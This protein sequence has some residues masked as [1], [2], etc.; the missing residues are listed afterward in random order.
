MHYFTLQRRNFLHLL[1]CCFYLYGTN[2][3]SNFALT[4]YIGDFNRS[5]A[6]GA[7]VA[8]DATTV[9]TNPAG[10][11]RLTGQQFS[12]SAQYFTT[13]AKFTDNGSKDALGSPL[14]G[15]NTG[16][17]GGNTFVPGIFYSNQLSP[18]LSFGLAIN[19]SFGLSTDYA[20]DWVG[21][22]TAITTSIMAM[23]INP[24]FTIKLNDAWSAG[25][26]ISAQQAQAKLSSAI[27]FGAVCLA[28][29]AP[30]TCASLGMPAPQS[31]DGYVEMNGSDWGSGY[32]F[33]LLWS[34]AN[35]QSSQATRVGM[36][37]R[38]K[39]SYQLTGDANF[40]IPAAATAFNPTFT[41]TTVT[42]PL[43]LPEI[44][45][46]SIYHDVTHSV[47]MMADIT[48][49][50]WSRFKNL[51]IDFANPAQPDQLIAKNWHD[52]NRY[53]IGINYQH[54]R[55]WV[56]Q[57]GVAYE[58]SPIPDSSYDPSIPVGNTLWLSL[59]AQYRFSEHRVL[60]AGWA[61]VQLQQREVNLTGNYGETLRGN[62]DTQLDVVN[63]RLNW[64]F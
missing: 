53:A 19:G 44:F 42:I 17:G 34:S 18:T 20:R 58:K 24:S 47:A 22:Y 35:N 6:G 13:A 33:G 7:A 10:L 51:S 15:G 49:T 26:G 8:E 40:S 30:S 50:R 12:G 52:T 32:N 62:T 1:I 59:G 37:Y 43:T 57:G 64:A 28:N 46:L 41:D 21:R 29:L 31:A 36:A 54:D 38:S 27:D 9:F 45:S 56:F 48:R 23:N 14:S 2:S 4:P 60:E 39:I 61:H 25:V 63:L 3:W 11:T 5:R 16:D 55:S